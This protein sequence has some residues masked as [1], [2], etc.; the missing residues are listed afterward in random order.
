MK[1][2]HI[3]DL[4]NYY[5]NGIVRVLPQHIYAQSQYADVA[6]MNV[7][8]VELVKEYQIKFDSNSWIDDAIKK[9]DGLDIVIF[10]DVYSTAYLRLYK[11]LIK[12]NIP[13]I[14][15]PHGCL[16][17]EAQNK[18]R[19]KKIIGNVL[20]FN[21]FIKNARAL[22]CLS[23][24]ELNNTKFNKNK[25]IGTNG[26]SLPEIEKKEFSSKGTK[27]VYIGRLDALHKGLDI[28]IEAVAENAEHFRQTGSTLSIYGP[29][30]VGRFA[31]VKELIDD[32][33]VADIVKLNHEVIGEEKEKVLLDSDVFI[34]T[35]RFEGMPMGILE[36]MSYGLPCLVTKGTTLQEKIVS[37]N[38]G[39]GAD[40]N[41][42][43]VALKIKVAIE[44]NEDY[45]KKGANARQLIADKFCWDTIA[46][47]T[48]NEYKILLNEVKN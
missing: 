40:T 23:E 15:I 13:Y 25:F 34:Q 29:D 42:K 38:A 26:I 14:I 39:W 9:L 36:A 43:E 12:S 19:L 8:N 1:I 3:S 48:I 2:L 5:F 17:K 7:T 27:F 16:S 18:K 4:N 28:M 30:L 35:S 44:E 37:N 33:N 20:F 10:H 46:K 32:N 24:F 11:Q 41:V 22:Q 47:F 21:K 45:L 31:H 6:Y